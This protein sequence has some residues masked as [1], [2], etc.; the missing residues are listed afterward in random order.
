MTAFSNPIVDLI[1]LPTYTYS[2]GNVTTVNSDNCPNRERVN[3][4]RLKDG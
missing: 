4:E 2:F 3:N 1:I